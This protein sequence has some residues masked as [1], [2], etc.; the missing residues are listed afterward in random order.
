MKSQ[1]GIK[2]RAVHAGQKPDA[3]YGGAATPI[4]QSSTFIY[5]SAE[6][7][8][9]RFAGEDDGFIYT[10]WG[11]PTNEVF[12]NKIAEL[13]G[14]EAALAVASGM[15]AVSMAILGSVKAGEH[16]VACKTLYSGTNTFLTNR[17]PGFGIDVSFVDPSNVS[18]FEKAIQPNTK[19]IYLESPGNPTLEI[20][21]LAAAA[22]LAKSRGIRTAID[23]TFATPINQRPGELGIDVVLHSATKFLGGHGDLIGG[24]ITASRKI[25][26]EFW[27][28]FIELGATLSPFHGFLLVRGMQT[29]PLRMAEHNTNAQKL[30]EFLKSHSEV[31]QVFYPGLPSFPGHEIACK[32]MS[33]FG[34]V[35]CI[36]VADLEKGR[37][38]MNAIELCSLTVSLGD[39]KTL[40][41]HPASMTHAKVSPEARA[42][43]GITD[44]LIRIAVGIEDIEDLI[45]D[46]DQALRA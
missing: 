25:I 14:M 16:I 18:N 38:I 31:S 12:E 4:I 22:G 8:A 29:L 7:A 11:N 39:V 37:R 34:G 21:D 35:V 19:L 13:E 41:S 28:M 30:A 40:I 43:A 6:E 24:V 33:G 45:N 5:E 10:R 20:I 23:N 27:P 1:H 15:A 42:A 26:D 44:G 32:Q 46:L 2:T 36:E 9:A 3:G 17:A